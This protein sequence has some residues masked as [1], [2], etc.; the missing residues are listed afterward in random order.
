M[1]ILSSQR[2]LPAVLI[3]SL[4]LAACGGHD[5][6]GSPVPPGDPAWPTIPS[7]P[8]RPVALTTFQGS[9]QVIGQPD[10]AQNG[11]DQGGAPGANTLEVPGAAAVDAS[12]KLFVA[13]SLNNRVLVWSSLPGVSDAGAAFV[14]GQ[15]DFATT[16]SGLSRTGLRQ[17]SHV[18]IGAGKL[19]VSDRGNNRVLIF[20]S[21]PA[22]GAAQPDLVLG[23]PDFA[24]GAAGCAATRMRAPSGAF[25]TPSGKVV[26]ADEGNSRV[27]IWNQMPTTNGQAPDVIVGQSDGTH[28]A[29]NDDSQDGAA[30][31][32]PT[33]RVLNRPGAVW[34]SGDRLYVADSLN[35]RVLLW[36]AVPT[37]NFQQADLVLGQGD[38]NHAAPND[39]DQDMTSEGAPTAR[40]LFSPDSIAVSDDGAQVVVGDSSN[41]R[42]LIWNAR[43]TTNFQ[44]ADV[45]LG[46]PDFVRHVE[47]DDDLDGVSGAP[48]SRTFSKPVAAYHPAGLL[49]ADRSNNRVL[50]LRNP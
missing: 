46:H 19:V 14:I 48:S 39:D 17:P 15:P 3:C 21:V 20:G 24:S 49:I 12:G 7:D 1:S 41:N 8:Q 22:S 27:L 16:A 42:V 40:T 37:A 18:T 25:V 28:C 32:L 6:A 50:V 23:Q 36:D 43:P 45:V 44:N 47:N 38:F 34:V 2:Q 9:S 35:N 31:V 5:E 4:L 13:D 33:A 30:E 29:E 11:P 26:V 10:F